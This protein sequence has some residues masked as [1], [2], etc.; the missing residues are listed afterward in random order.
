MLVNR[1]LQFCHALFSCVRPRDIDFLKKHLSATELSLFFTMDLPTQTHCLRVARTCL[2]LLP[3]DPQVNKELLLKAAL[4][5]DVGKPANLIKTK[6]K[7]LIVI[8]TTLAPQLYD[9][10]LR[11]KR[12]GGHFLQAATAH[13]R[14][15][16]AGAAIARRANLHP[17]VVY[18]I[19]NHHRLAVAGEPPEL[20]ILRQADA[21]N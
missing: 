5:H 7:V 10:I 3:Q 15:P 1:I 8:M 14:H 11:Q 2:K 9:K 16:S 6:D 19:E 20:K 4:L 18:L 13:A 12:F 17:E 21:L